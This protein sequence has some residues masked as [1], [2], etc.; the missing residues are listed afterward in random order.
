MTTKIV[1]GINGQCIHAERRAPGD[2]DQCWSDAENESEIASLIARADDALVTALKA[3]GQARSAIGELTGSRVY[4]IELAEG[5]EGPD[6]AAE[7]ERAALSLRHA[8]R[9]IAH[10]KRILAEEAGQ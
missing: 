1:P 4:D 5:T 8:H 6:A 9:I 7:L 3:T 10:R 2:C